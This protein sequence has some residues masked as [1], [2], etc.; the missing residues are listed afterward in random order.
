MIYPWDR[1]MSGNCKWN[2]G[3]NL[4]ELSWERSHHLEERGQ[5]DKLNPGT[6]LYTQAG[7]GRSEEDKVPV[8][9]FTGSSEYI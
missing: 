7:W 9:Q 8:P 2:D 3:I 6:K 4:V 5:A 1:A